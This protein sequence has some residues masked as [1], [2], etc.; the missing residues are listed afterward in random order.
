MEKQMT[1]RQYQDKLMVD[2][3]SDLN[4]NTQR[5]IVYPKNYVPQ[6]ALLNALLAL[7]QATDKN[8]SPVLQV[9]SS[10]SVKQSILDM[11][12]KGLN[13]G[14]SQGYFIAY[15]KKLTWFTSYFGHICQAMAADPNIKEIYGEVVYQDDVF[16]Y[17]IKGGKKIVLEHQQDPDNIDAKKIKGCYAT[18]VY[19]DDSE[20]SEYMTLEQIKRSWSFGQTK[21]GSSAHRETPEEMCKRT[22]INRLTKQI[23]N[24]SDDSMIVDQVAEIDREADEN[25]GSIMVDITPDDEQEAAQDQ[26]PEQE[27]ETDSEPQ[28]EPEPV[29]KAEPVKAQPSVSKPPVKAAETPLPEAPPLPSEDEEQMQLPF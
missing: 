26:E 13:V 19:R 5:G 21:G 28:P 27:P 2:V 12:Q 23:I 17:Q 10:E 20:V 9:C 15:G 25:Q 22:V 24:S 14:K 1:M 18:I 4:V 8:G 7:A 11:L 29:R 6:N 3:L 16:K